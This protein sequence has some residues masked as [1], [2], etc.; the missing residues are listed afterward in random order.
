VR[1]LPYGRVGR[2]EAACRGEGEWK[3]WPWS[4]SRAGGKANLCV[5]KNL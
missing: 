3:E 5:K 2:L 4:M 1:K